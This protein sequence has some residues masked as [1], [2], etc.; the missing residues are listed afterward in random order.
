MAQG[1]RADSSQSLQEEQVK[2]G[3]PGSQ[4]GQSV[5]SQMV[6]GNSTSQEDSS[7]AWKAEIT[8]MVC[9]SFIHIFSINSQFG[10]QTQF[11]F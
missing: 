3:Q 6:N 8:R 11:Q 2:T 5:P 9:K 7:K 4:S 10:L 1:A